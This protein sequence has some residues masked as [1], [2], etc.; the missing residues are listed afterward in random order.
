[1]ATKF[2]I[3]E[4][5][6]RLHVGYEE[7]LRALFE[8]K[9]ISPIK[10]RE[11]GF[12]LDDRQ[13]FDIGKWLRRNPKPGLTVQEAAEL[14]D[15]DCDLVRHARRQ[16]LPKDTEFIPEQDILR[17]RNWIRKHGKTAR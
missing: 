10:F 12:R 15:C 7:L 6:E 16:L 14:L 3:Y 9:E 13:V 17:F 5:A 11:T 4:A 1:M 2:T 8:M